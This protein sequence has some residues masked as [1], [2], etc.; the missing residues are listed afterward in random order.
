MNEVGSLA[1]GNDQT[2]APSAGREDNARPRISDGVLYLLLAALIFGAWQYSKLGHFSSKDDIGYWLGVVGG[3][4][5]LLLFLYPLRKRWS[6]MHS[7]G[8]IK[9]WFAVHM[10]FGILGPF[11]ILVHSTFQLGSMNA[12]IALVAMLIVAGSGIIGRFIYRHIHHGLL[13][14]KED[15]RE[16]EATAGFQQEAVKSRFHRIPEVEARLLAFHARCL[17]GDAGWNTYLRRV[18]VLPWQKRFEYAACCVHLDRRLVKL[19]RARRW[20][21]SDLNSRRR[22][23]RSLI[24][25]YLAS[26]VRVAQFSAYERLFALW[27]VLHVPF[28]YIL[29]LSSVAHVVAVHVY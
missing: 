17:Q 25:A 24:R 13:G 12:S 10:A 22:R 8:G 23:A 21:R 27:H 19:A 29:V 7:W 6:V 28:L 9:Y 20:S 5:M 26:V 11:L 4:M 16:L 2:L 18:L 3:T 15:L 1:G 14:K